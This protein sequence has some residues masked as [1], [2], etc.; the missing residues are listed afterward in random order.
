MTLFRRSF[1]GFCLAG[2]VGLLRLPS[3]PKDSEDFVFCEC[4][5]HEALL[6]KPDLPRIRKRWVRLRRRPDGTYDIRLD[7]QVVVDVKSYRRFIDSQP[8][9]YCSRKT[10]EAIRQIAG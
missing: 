8:K 6:N 10:L 3:R 7:G 2:L 4:Y 5:F 9:I 1:F